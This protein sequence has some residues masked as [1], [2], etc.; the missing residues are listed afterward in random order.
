MSKPHEYKRIDTSLIVRFN[1][2]D[3]R[4]F[5]S[6][7]RSHFQE[8]CYYA[9]KIIK[10]KFE[11]EDITVIAFT[12]L[13]EQRTEF[14][15]LTHIKNFLYLLVR[16]ASI[17]YL[18]NQKVQNKM[19]G[20]LQYLTPTE[21]HFTNN[22]RIV[23]EFLHIIHEQIEQLPAQCKRVFKLLFIN[24]L[25]FKEVSNE[26]SITESTVR[27][28]KFK[29][30]SILRKKIFQDDI[31]VSITILMALAKVLG[32][33]LALVLLIRFLQFPV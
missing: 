7:F 20:E 26:L 28:L 21:E 23:S 31:L 19:K 29:A 32:L 25:S 1:E 5:D 11:A 13:W 14:T 8:L 6:I 22:E 4:A 17:N 9:E 18:R 10:D 30:I 2:G 33:L 12:K 3:S 16:N 15:T 24:G 27:G